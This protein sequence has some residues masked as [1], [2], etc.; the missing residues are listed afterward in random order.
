[1]P[2]FENKIVLVGAYF[3]VCIFFLIDPTPLLLI[4]KLYTNQPQH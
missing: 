1:M 4:P 3:V 2:E